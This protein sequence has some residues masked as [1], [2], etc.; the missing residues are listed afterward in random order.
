MLRWLLLLPVL[1]L[2]RGMQDHSVLYPEV[3][4]ELDNGCR[5]RQ[6]QHP[7]QLVYRFGRNV[8]EHR[9]RQRVPRI[10]FIC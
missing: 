8:V 4:F 9:Y 3:K 7:R 2:P 5:I 6:Q 10:D 1:Q